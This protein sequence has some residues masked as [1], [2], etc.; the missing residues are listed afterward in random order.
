MSA[1]FIDRPEGLDLANSIWVAALSYHA[2]TE[3]QIK[4]GSKFGDGDIGNSLQGH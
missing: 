1:D 2:H 4:I 3:I